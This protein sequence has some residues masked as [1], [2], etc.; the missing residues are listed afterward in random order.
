MGIFDLLFGKREMDVSGSINN[1]ESNNVVNISNSKHIAEFMIEDVFTITGRGT[2]VTGRVLR[3]S[4]K[5][6][7]VVVLGNTGI[8]TEI[9]GIEMFRKQ[10]DEVIEGDNAG[11]LLRGVERNNVARGEMLYK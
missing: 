1:Q 11:I 6:G 8:T 2:V 7:D 3:G 9:S 10:L 5:L 4:F